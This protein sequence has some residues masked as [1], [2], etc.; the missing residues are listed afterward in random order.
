MVDF[1][2]NWTLPIGAVGNSAYR[3]GVHSVRLKTEPIKLDH[4]PMTGA[5]GNRTYQVGVN[6]VGNQ[7]YRGGVNAVGNR[8][9]RVVLCI[10]ICPQLVVSLLL[11]EGA[12]ATSGISPLKSSVTVFL[13]RINT[14]CP[15]TIKS[16]VALAA[17]YTFS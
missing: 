11:T 5:V 14:A 17:L 10:F 7:T 6:A 2:I 9:Y 13:M 15:R 3:G 12:A 16:S 8:T 1:R 4:A